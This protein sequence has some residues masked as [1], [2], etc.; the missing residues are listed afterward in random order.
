MRPKPPVRGGFNP[1]F[2][3]LFDSGKVDVQVLGGL[4]GR[5]GTAGG[6]PRFPKLRGVQQFPAGLA[7]VPP[8]VGISAVRTGSPDIPVRQETAAGAAMELLNGMFSNKAVG[9]KVFEDILDDFSLN[10]GRS[11]PEFIKGNGKPTVNSRMDGM[12]PIAEFLRAYPLF[13]GLIFSGG[14]VFIGTAHVE[15]LISS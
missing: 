11:S 15:G 2:Q 3:R 6:A 12:I 9:I 1:P 13:R 5:R 4:Q 8:G 10:R 7:L 14:A